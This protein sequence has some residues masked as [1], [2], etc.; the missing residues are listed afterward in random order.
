MPFYSQQSI[1]RKK[2]DDSDEESK[3]EKDSASI[4]S[5]FNHKASDS[6]DEDYENLCENM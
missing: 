1:V 4:G 5:P 2:E 3:E 6:E